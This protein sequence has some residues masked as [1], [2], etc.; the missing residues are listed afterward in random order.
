MDLFVANKQ[1]YVRGAGDVNF[2]YRN[3]LTGTNNWVLIKCVGEQSNKSAIGAKVWLTAE[4]D[5]ESVTQFREVGC[6]STFLGQ[7][8]LRAHFGLGNAKT[9]KTIKIEWPSGQIDSYTGIKP[10]QQY[11]ATEGKDLTP[12]K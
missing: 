1:G 2:L 10:K 6:M 3:D 9:I 8:D 12:S 4:I 5:G 11:T 7:N